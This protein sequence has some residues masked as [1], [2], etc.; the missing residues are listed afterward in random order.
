[1]FQI[2]AEHASLLDSAARFARERYDPGSARDGHAPGGAFDA[3]RWKEIA[4]LGWL[5][6]TVDENDGGLGL[7]YSVLCLLAEALA[8]ALMPEPFIVQVGVAGYLLERAAPGMERDAVLGAWLG[9][10]TLLALAHHE[11]REGRCFGLDV[12]LSARGAGDKLVLNGHKCAVLDACLAE[13]FI[14][15]AQAESDRGTL[16]LLV[17]ANSPG[18]RA[19][20]YATF[21]GRGISDLEFKDVEVAATARLDCA[22]TA[23]VLIDE[24]LLLSAL[25]KAAETLGLVRLLL[26]MTH[27][28]LLEREQFGVK[29]AE[30]QVLQHRLV[31]MHLA[32]VRLES[33]L[34]LAGSKLDELGVTGAAAYIAAA[35][36]QAAEVGRV[37]GQQAIQLHGAIG[38]TDELLVGRY[39][40]RLTANQLSSGAE[41]EHLARLNNG[42]DH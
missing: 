15:S 7:D 32:I 2:S 5:A 25:L 31:D 33:Q 1:M 23:A 14:V 27:R 6:A 37:V 20:H 29:L 4:D 8:P 39:F 13:H 28:H 10:E 34:V 17:A 9:G 42:L 21:D 3:R 16:A 38:M 18:L 22:P 26:P 12:A 19:E 30:L 11:Q 36:V 40:K 35:I 41:A 24:A